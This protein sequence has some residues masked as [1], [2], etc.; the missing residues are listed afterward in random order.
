ML[1]RIT[2]D[3]RGYDRLSKYVVEIRGHNFRNTIPTYMFLYRVKY[4]Y[5]R[6]KTDGWAFKVKIGEIQFKWAK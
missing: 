2:Q 6:E 4:K 3:G 5:N 1:L